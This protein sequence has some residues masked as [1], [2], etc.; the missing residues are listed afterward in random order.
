MRRVPW[1]NARKKVLVE[2]SKS[3]T[4][5]TYFAQNRKTNPCFRSSQTCIRLYNRGKGWCI[6][7]LVIL[8]IPLSITISIEH[9]RRDLFIDMVVGFIFKN[10]QITLF[11][12][13]TLVLNTGK[14]RPENGVIFYYKLEEKLNF[15]SLLH[16]NDFSLVA[17]V[18]KIPNKV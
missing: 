13:F 5:S 14:G 15:F 7:G 11:P 12:G 9:T 2:I 3:T 8:K 17:C 10:N 18:L 4:L 1:K 16:K 6:Y